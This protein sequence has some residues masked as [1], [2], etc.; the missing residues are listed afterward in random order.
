M[1]RT[2]PPNTAAVNQVRGGRIPYISSL[3][4]P[5][6]AARVRGGFAA[7]CC[8]RPRD[9]PGVNRGRLAAL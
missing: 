2:R 9:A 7:R 6:F 4:F 8:L 5:L 3:L 1:G